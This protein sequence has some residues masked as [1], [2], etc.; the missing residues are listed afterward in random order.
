[1][2]LKLSD[3]LFR[4]AVYPICHECRVGIRGNLDDLIEQGHQAERQRRTAVRL[5]ICGFIF[6]IVIA[7]YTALIRY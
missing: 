5:A 7:T 6:C 2:E 3:D 4:E 1:V